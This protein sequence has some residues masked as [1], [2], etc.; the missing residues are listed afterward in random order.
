MPIRL[1]LLAEAQAAEEERRR[2]P[3]KRFILVAVLLVVGMLVWSGTIQLKVMMY[4]SELGTMDGQVASLTNKYTTVLEQQ[5]R[6]KDTRRKLDALNSLATNRFLQ[7]SLMDAMQRSTVDHVQLT[8]LK[9][10]QEYTY[11][12]EVKGRT[13]AGRITPGKPPTVKEKITIALDAKDSSPNPGDQI[14]PLREA[15]GTNIF[16]S[17]LLGK[18]NEVVMT[19][20]SQ[21]QAVAG[22][23]PFVLFTIECRIPEKTR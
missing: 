12:P 15:V 2:D 6:A 11:T 3:V 5:A 1:N 19:K 16:F 14:N 4:R 21:P 13:N 10:L 7:G 9:I 8:R 23:P 22:E 17:T 20:L 18:N